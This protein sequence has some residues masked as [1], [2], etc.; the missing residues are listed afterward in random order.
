MDDASP[1]FAQAQP[2]AGVPIRR[3]QLVPSIKTLLSLRS[4]RLGSLD[5]SGCAHR[6]LEWDLEGLYYK[7]IERVDQVSEDGLGQRNSSWDA[8]WTTYILRRGRSTEALQP[9]DALLAFLR[10]SGRD[11][12]AKRVGIAKEDQITKNISSPNLIWKGHC[13]FCGLR[14]QFIKRYNMVAM[15]GH[16]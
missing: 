6:Q 2:A 10:E 1:H 16:L 3:E 15:L 14:L 4:A 7:M 12:E 5:V 9:Y 8:V 11:E 13:A